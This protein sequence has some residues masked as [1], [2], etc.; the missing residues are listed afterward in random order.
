MIAQKR[1]P[2]LR[3]RPPVPCHILVLG[4]RRL[5]DVDAKLEQLAMDPRRSPERVGKADVTDQFPDVR[6]QLRTAARR[7]RLPSP[8]KAGIA[9]LAESS[10]IENMNLWP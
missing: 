1:L 10:C 8:V 6:R 3:R 9:V 7:S 4:D 5:A 2:P